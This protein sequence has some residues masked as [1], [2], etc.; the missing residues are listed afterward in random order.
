MALLKA[1]EFHECMEEDNQAPVLTETQPCDPSMQPAEMLFGIYTEVSFRQAPLLLEHGTLLI[2]TGQDQLS[3]AVKFT[4]CL[5]TLCDL[6]LGTQSS[7]HASSAL[8]PAKLCQS[9]NRGFVVRIS[10]KSIPKEGHGHTVSLVTV[11]GQALG[12]SEHYLFIF[13]WYLHAILFLALPCT[14]RSSLLPAAVG[15]CPLLLKFPLHIPP[16]ISSPA[17]PS[18]NTRYKPNHTSPANLKPGPQTYVT[19]H[20][21]KC[22]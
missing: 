5:A 10:L 22:Q 18:R 4:L 11:P 13:I 3:A 17:C 2:P 21:L 20:M 6:K 12:P 14:L 15:S 19:Y 8:T 1:V 7:R 16:P 9:S